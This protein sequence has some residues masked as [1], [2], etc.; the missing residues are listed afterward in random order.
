MVSAGA[1]LVP[2]MVG[3]G[4]H[5]IDYNESYSVDPVPNSSFVPSWWNDGFEASNGECGVPY[6]R[7]HAGPSTGNGLYWYSFSYGSVFVVQLS[8]E[9]ELA[10]GSVQYNWLAAQL[11]AVNRSATPW[12]VVT[13]H[14]PIYTTQECEAGDYVVSLHLRRHLDDLF[15]QN[16][17]CRDASP[18]AGAPPLMPAFLRR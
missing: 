3:P 15:Y 12:V 9:H 4:N 10:I 13:L 2:W 18:R 17:V 6:S 16:Q 11:A 8:S 7:R 1:A 5:E 14:R